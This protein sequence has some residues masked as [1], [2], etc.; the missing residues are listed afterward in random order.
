MINKILSVTAGLLLLAFVANSAAVRG[1][2]FENAPANVFVYE[3]LPAPMPSTDTDAIVGN[4]WIEE[5]TLANKTGSSDTCSVFDKQ[6]TP[7]EVIPAVPIA[8]NTVY[9]IDYKARYAPGGVSWS[10]TTGTGVIGTLRG[11]RLNP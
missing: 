1:P 2:L 9:V 3:T 8:G 11:K 7:R 10:C 4:F 6:G 5:I